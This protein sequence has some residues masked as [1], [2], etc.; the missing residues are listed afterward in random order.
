MNENLLAKMARDLQATEEN[1]TSQ[2]L[3]LDQRAALGQAAIEDMVM[4]TVTQ[5]E[6]IASARARQMEE[7][8]CVECVC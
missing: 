4:D 6:E 7:T 8:C 2:L 3:S 1:V 5:R